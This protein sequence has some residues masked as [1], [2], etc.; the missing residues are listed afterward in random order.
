MTM[1]NPTPGSIDIADRQSIGS[2]ATPVPLL[3]AP[4]SPGTLFIWHA[5]GT[6]SAEETALIAVIKNAQN[7]A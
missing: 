4:R 6:G 1:D 2:P 5:Y 3:T 7:I